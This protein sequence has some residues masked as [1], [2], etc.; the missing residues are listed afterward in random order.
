MDFHVPTISENLMRGNAGKCHTYI[1]EFFSDRRASSSDF[2]TKLDGV[3]L[4]LATCSKIV[5]HLTAFQSFAAA[6]RGGD[7]IATRM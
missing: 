3:G 7:I 2:K 1:A 4:N 5:S 6:K